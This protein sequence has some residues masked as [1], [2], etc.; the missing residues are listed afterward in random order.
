MTKKNTIKLTE[1][2]LKKII[3]ESVKKVLKEQ[4]WDDGD[5]DME[6]YRRKQMRS[7]AGDQDFHDNNEKRIKELEP[8]KRPYHIINNI[9]PEDAKVI[10][11]YKGSYN[12][13]HALL[14]E[15]ASKKITLGQAI[16]VL[17]DQELANNVQDAK[18]VL[19]QA[20]ENRK[21]S[22]VSRDS[23][24]F[25]EDFATQRFNERHK[26]IQGEF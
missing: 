26:S 5:Y 22:A 4:S 25:G 2:E 9:S 16:L 13:I 17:M 1:S 12:T 21:K 19:R 7:W 20:L 24:T 6:L 10:E 18:S 8:N 11:R 15:L 23:K 3:S 14:S